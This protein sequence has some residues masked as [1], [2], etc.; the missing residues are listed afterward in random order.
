MKAHILNKWNMQENENSIQIYWKD[1]L[2]KER[3]RCN[4]Y[5]EKVIVNSV[6]A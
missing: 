1:R 5:S 4:K 6:K 2:K 3:E